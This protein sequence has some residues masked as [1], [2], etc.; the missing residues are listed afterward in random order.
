MALHFSGGDL[1]SECIK[2]AAL[3]RYHHQAAGV[4][5]KPVHN[6]RAGQG[7][8]GRVVVQQGIEQCAA[9]VARGGVYDHAHGFVD[10]EQVRIFIHHIERNILRHKG[11]RL[12]CGTQ[13]KQVLV[14]REH[15]GGSF[16][17]DLPVAA[18]QAINNELLEV[19]ARKFGKLQ[20]QKTIEPQTVVRR[21]G[22]QQTLFVRR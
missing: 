4:F 16:G 15:F 3:T 21:G 5:I 9:P 8:R 12:C 6:A 19:A 7:G 22:L 1:R 18:Q 11:L 20:R 2:G 10:D 17:A 13:N 14:A